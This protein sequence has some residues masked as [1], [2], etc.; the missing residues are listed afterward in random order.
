MKKY[1][2][3]EIQTVAICAATIICGSQ[4]GSGQLDGGSRNPVGGA[5]AAPG[6]ALIVK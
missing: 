4:D 6:R 2:I 1:I 3:P 5:T